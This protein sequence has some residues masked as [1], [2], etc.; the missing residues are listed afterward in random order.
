MLYRKLQRR[1]VLRLQADLRVPVETQ[2]QQHYVLSLVHDQVSEAL[3]R[4]QVCAE[5]DDHPRGIDQ[6]DRICI[7]K[8]REGRES[9]QFLARPI[10]GAVA[11]M[12]VWLIANNVR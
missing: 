3:S 10:V 5:V 6:L 9:S 1:E 2:R 7:R 8:G 4:S 11:E 12:L